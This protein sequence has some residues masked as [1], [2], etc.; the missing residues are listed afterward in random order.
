MTI[1]E[2]LSSRIDA[3]GRYRT[4]S[5]FG[6]LP[7]LIAV[8]FLLVSCVSLTGITEH[9]VFQQASPLKYWI[10][11][12]VPIGGAIIVKMK[13]YD[14]GLLAVAI[15][16]APFDYVVSFTPFSFTPL[17]VI[18]AAALVCATFGPSSLIKRR[19][20]VIRTMTVLFVLTILGPL[21]RSEQRVNEV[22]LIASCLAMG[23]L[24]S[25]AARE[26]VG[27]QVVI[28]S[29]VASCTIQGALGIW[30]YV[31]GSSLNFYS[32]SSATSY[33][34]NYFFQFEGVFRVSA[35]FPNPI[36]MGN[37]L[38]MAVPML[39]V[40]AISA[41]GVLRVLVTLASALIV[42]LATIATLS[43][44]SWI[45][46]V[47]GVVIMLIFL[48]A[49]RTVVALVGTFV[50]AV[51]AVAAALS[52]AGPVL[53]SRAQTIFGHSVA[54][55]GIT[56]GDIART[57]VQGQALALFRAHPF[58]GV[59]LGNLSPY[60]GS[61]V[62]QGGQN[63]QNNLYQLMAEAG[64]IAMIAILLL[65]GSLVWVAVRSLGT[66]RTMAALLLAE[67]GIMVTA[68]STDANYR[69]TQVAVF[70]AII[71]GLASSLS[72]GDRSEV[73]DVAH[74]ASQD[75]ERSLVT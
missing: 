31:T 11:V 58:T 20:T 63:A 68:S 53:I 22:I 3:A 5:E 57:L 55:P 46:A 62:I 21:A 65:L 49:R 4:A 29:F 38:A 15:I 26:R 7:S 13:R 44:S 35:A 37:V 47:V 54:T 40:C 25:I 39:I 64:V 16:V 60:L 10:T 42:I 19:P 8:A 56:T 67:V 50:V 9:V 2:D 69:Y 45:A 30:E 34:S 33:A 73:P 43:R 71:F 72:S 17:E 74:S 41:R 75:D 14:L 18:L 61:G 52:F 59:G 51:A 27:R 12:L 1:S 48:S 6:L 23:Y 66:H 28:V 70:V 36:A 24:V 32:S